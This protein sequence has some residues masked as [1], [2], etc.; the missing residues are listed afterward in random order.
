ME[1]KQIRNLFFWIF[2]VL[3]LVAAPLVS[4]HALGF[5]FEPKN[6][7]LVK[8]GIITVNAQP[9]GARVFLNGRLL[10]DRMPVA[11]PGLRTGRYRVEVSSP[12]YQTWDRELGVEA[13]EVTRL[14]RVLLVPTS[15]RATLPAQAPVRA[16]VPLAGGKHLVLMGPSG[17]DTFV[18]AFDLKKEISRRLF[19]WKHRPAEKV[20]SAILALSEDDR[21][22][23]ACF[24]EMS[25]EA[26]VVADFLEGSEMEKQARF[27]KR[28]ISNVRFHPKNSKGLFYLENGAL[29]EFDV[30]SKKEKKVTESVRRFEAIEDNVYY[31]TSDFRLFSSNLEGKEHVDLLPDKSLKRLLFGDGTKGDFVMFMTGKKD[32]FWLRGDG[33]LFMNRLPYFADEEVRGAQLAAGSEALIYWKEKEVWLLDLRVSKGRGESFFERGPKKIRLWHGNEA[34][35]AAQL[36]RGESH[37][38]VATEKK[39]IL[40]EVLLPVTGH[41]FVMMQHAMGK[42]VAF[43][44]DDDSGNLYWLDQKSGGEPTLQ[45]TKLF[46][47]SLFSFSIRFRRPFSSPKEVVL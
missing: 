26:C 17:S 46:E 8:T 39:L 25:G 11:I 1:L 35:V 16:L 30:E 37:A 28:G 6:F 14:E 42:D 2:V 47:P 41:S 9:K 34:V 44:L 31:L 23:L 20:F 27:L 33:L 40:V 15:P 12:G 18:D 13:E 43:Y 4:F 10:S 32:A 22:L 38:V 45:K 7:S 24:R 19:V 29:F 5:V 21:R 3:Y 36:V